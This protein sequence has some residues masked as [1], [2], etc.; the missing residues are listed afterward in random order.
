[1]HPQSPVRL[2][3]SFYGETP[4]AGTMSN[5]QIVAF[6]ESCG[7]PASAQDETP[8]CSAFLVWI[9]QQCCIDTPAN[10][11]AISWLNFSTHTDEPKLGDVVV[12]GWPKEA[13]TN[14][15]VGLFVR[16]VL[17]GIYVLAGNQDNKV[18]IALWKKE[19]VLS[20]RSSPFA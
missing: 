9:F 15:H 14:H 20:Y 19:D 16:E 12:L 3:L 5:P 1:M 10:A 18:D 6:L 2:A 4:L 17:G 7:L 13:P 8:W 11:A